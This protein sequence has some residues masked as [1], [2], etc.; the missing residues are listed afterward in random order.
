MVLDAVLSRK[1]KN[2][3]GNKNLVETIKQDRM[4]LQ[5]S[6]RPSHITSLQFSL[7]LEKLES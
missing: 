7:S 1:H 3:R 2:P 5:F 6:L 4:L